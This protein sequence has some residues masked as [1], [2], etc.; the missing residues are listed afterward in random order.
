MPHSS[1][2]RK[3]VLFE[4]NEVPWRVLE[5]HVEERPRGG[6]AKL[7]GRAQRF[8]TWAEERELSPWITWPSL[9]RGVGEE[10]HGITDFNQELGEVD[11]AHPPLW[12]L[13]AEAGVPVG[14]CGSVH[15]S[16]CPPDPGA[17]A[18]YLPDPF[19]RDARCHPPA[20][21]SFQEFQLAM[22]RRS[23]RNVSA[24][25]SWDHVGGLLRSA[26]G[27]G[28][29][30]R[31]FA[32][33]GRQ[34]L[35]ERLRP[36]TRVRRR[37]WQSVLAF[38]VFMNQLER[39]RP[40]FSTF[41]T[42]H[43]ASTLHRF[44]AAR[45]PA[46]YARFDLEDSWVE[47]YRHE[48]RWVLDRA[49]AMVERLSA[50]AQ[51]NPEYEL[52]VASSMGQAA[53]EARRTHS[54]LYLRDLG[55]FLDRLGVPRGSWKERPAMAPRVIFDLGGERDEGL[56][57]RLATVEVAGRPLDWRHLGEGVYRLH[58]GVQQDVVGARVR[59]EGRELR[60]EELGFQ[61]LLLEDQVGQTA[62]HVPEGVLLV[63]GAREAGAG[64][65]SAERTSLST[66]EVAPMVLE[67]FGLPRPAYMAPAPGR[68]F[69]LSA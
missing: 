67:R 23:A 13:L 40:A 9:H 29:G 63:A 60:P 56:E 15:S 45:Y 68:A 37:S 16:P 39:T 55:V 46:D 6:L 52:W 3:I 21:R 69:A 48:I 5:D 33:V 18:F 41:F 66:L 43:V 57:A 58:P 4:L 10:R 50:F 22:S 54:Q 31:T 64:R 59:C 25:I 62:Y 26:P 49:D 2:S 38:E 19:A 30:P 42:N 11:R 36:W 35:D 28:L 17:Y 44:W 34:L 47:T 12:R 8:E 51:R 65:A 7:L 14:V 20:V 32:G 27:I 61:N 53:T 24:R 1:A